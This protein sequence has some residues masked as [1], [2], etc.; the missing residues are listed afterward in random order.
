M[1]IRA[2]EDNLLCSQQMGKFMLQSLR[3]CLTGFVCRHKHE[4]LQRDKMFPQHWQQRIG[5]QLL[6]LPQ[7]ALT[8][9]QR[10]MGTGQQLSKRKPPQAESELLIHELIQALFPSVHLAQISCFLLKFQMT[11]MGFLW[12]LQKREWDACWT[13]SAANG[14]C[15]SAHASPR[16]GGQRGRGCG[17]PCRGQASVW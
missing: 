11:R 16:Q 15:S 7:S 10:L 8:T 4:Q 12:V 14:L 1:D 2:S 17:L 13:S 3:S 6:R 9:Q 5:V